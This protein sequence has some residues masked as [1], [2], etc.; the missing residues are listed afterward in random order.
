M[1]KILVPLAAK[2]LSDK[3]PITAVNFIRETYIKKLAKYGL[4]PVFASHVLPRKIVLELYG[5]AQGILF[6]G[7]S[8]ID[9]ALYGKRKNPKTRTVEP[10]RDKLEIFLAKK[11]MKDKK[12]ILAICR[13]AQILAVASG[14]ELIQHIPDITAE[15]HIGTYEGLATHKKHPV[16]LEKN[17]RA[18]ALLKREKI[19]VNSAHHQAVKNPGKNFLIS[20]ITFGGITEIIEHRD[21]SYF[22]FGLQSHPEAETG[23]LEIF[24]KKFAEVA[25]KIKW[26]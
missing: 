26:N 15:R 17:S 23:A 4:T 6:T 21:R 1:I 5:E 8:D 2:R 20:G 7:G 3:E 22:C 14:G 11:A 16:W 18:R 19:F 24:F 25:K 9:P 13:G 12:P 10:E